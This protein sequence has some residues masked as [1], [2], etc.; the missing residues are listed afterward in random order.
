[1][2]RNNEQDRRDP[3]SGASIPFARGTEIEREPA[4]AL[5]LVPDG[6]GESAGGEMSTAA[7]ELAHAVVEALERRP[8]AR[9]TPIRPSEKRR[10]RRRL[11]VTFSEAAT[12]DR[13]RELA[14][15]WG[16]YAPDGESPNVSAVVE[17]LLMP[18][19]E[20]AERGEIEWPD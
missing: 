15:E 2:S 17:F 18:R 3:L 8:T 11:G 1:M 14:L 9:D 6:D 19:L 4:A 7:T 12:P 20:A 16:L 5:G 13:I 10:K